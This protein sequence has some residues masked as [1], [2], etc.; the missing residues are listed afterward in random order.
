MHYDIIIIGSGPA[1]L[2]AGLYAARGQMRT[3]ILEKGGFGG[4][5]ATS[6][7]V[8]NYPGAPTD[9]TGPSLTERMREQ[10][11]DFGVEFQTEEFKYFEKTGQT[12]E[13]TTSSTVYQT[14][15]IIVATGAQPKLLGCPGELEFRGLG[16]SYCATCDANFF[17]NLEIAV[18][19]GGDTAI[20][21]AIY[22][23]KFASKVTVIHRRDKLRAA[24]VLQER[25]MENEKIRFVWDSV[26][27]EI[28]GDGL[29]QSIVVKNVKDGALTE[30]PVQG[31]FVYVGQIP[32]TQYF[33]GTLEKDARDYLITDEDMCTNIPG[34]FAAGDVR[35]KSLRQVVTAAGDGA[36]AAVSAIKYI[37]DYSEVAES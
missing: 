30:I 13:V 20:E 17:R 28:K 15:A 19:G 1:G 26:V 6:W 32:H 11:V 22:L 12:F 37:E 9:T 18:V 36:I 5:I 33:V 8:E 4:Q 24:K 21:E 31:V 27:E 23:T 16:V 14:K 35:R 7:E 34:V 2:A 25:A 29:V 10:C 3:L